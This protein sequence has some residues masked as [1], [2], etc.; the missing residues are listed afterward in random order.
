MAQPINSFKQT[1]GQPAEPPKSVGW[2]GAALRRQLRRAERDKEEL[3]RQ[4]ERLER[5]LEESQ[6]QIRD[7]DK[8]LRDKDQAIA[9]KEKQI[10]DLERQLAA[11]K[12][13]STNSS[14]PPSSDGLVGD[15][16]TRKKR[17]KSRR[18]PGGQTGHD[19]NHRPLVEPERVNEVISILPAECKHCGH[20]L[21]QQPD[22]IQ[23]IGEVHRHQ[24]IEL[25]PIQAHITEYQCPKVVCQDCGKGTR[26]PLP[27]EFQDQTGPQLTALIAYMT[28]VC[29]MPCRVTEAFLEEAL[30]ISISLGSTQKAWE[31]ASAAA[32]QPYQELQQQLKNEPVLNSDETSWRNDGEKRW[33]WALVAQSFVF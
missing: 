14:K 30:H 27:S 31:Q 19:G 23:T 33:I 22:E 15:Q 11:R 4:N 29:R 32:Q 28:A 2:S 10:A 24:V 7:K 9:E 16:R 25:P 13:N 6:K 3:R 8:A 21:P 18:K 20:G 5:Q 12:K 26:A 17:K 1:T